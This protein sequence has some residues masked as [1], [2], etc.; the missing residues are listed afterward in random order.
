M[1]A[2]GKVLVVDADGKGDVRGGGDTPAGSGGGAV[3][4]DGVDQGRHD[5]AAECGD[6]RQDGL[7]EGGKF[8]AD[9]FPLD[10]KAHREEENHHQDVVDEFLHGHAPGEEPVYQTVRRSDVDGEFRVQETV[11]QAFGERQVRQEHGYGDA[12]KEDDAV[13]PR[14]F[15]EFLLGY[16]EVADFLVPPVDRNECHII[17]RYI[18]A[19]FR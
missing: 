12:G 5:D 9:H 8:P 19:V 13:G 15:G 10:F 3:V 14:L 11:I 7:F 1:P 4:H 6:D 16:L 2:A 18:F 17:R